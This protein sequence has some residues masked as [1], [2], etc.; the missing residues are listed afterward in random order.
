M[1]LNLTAETV[2]ASLRRLAANCLL[3]IHAT[4]EGDGFNPGQG[5]DVRNFFEGNPPAEIVWTERNKLAASWSIMIA[6]QASNLL[7]KAVIHPGNG[8]TTSDSPARQ[9]AI[10]VL[11]QRN[12]K[13]VAALE[14][15]YALRLK[16]PEEKL[17][18]RPI[19]DWD[20]TPYYWEFGGTPE[21]M[22]RLLDELGGQYRCLIDFSHAI[23]TV[24]QAQI[25]AERVPALQCC[26]SLERVVHGFMDLPHCEVCHFSGWPM[27]RLAGSHG[28]RLTPIPP[29]VLEALKTH[30]VICLERR[31]NP[32]EP[33]AT[34]SDL[35]TFREALI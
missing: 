1:V 25:W 5:I 24:H 19:P 15:M 23:V 6:A 20:S 17:I 4:G 2:V 26:Q 35:A 8:Q 7:T 34:K 11:Q 18:N 31:W 28:E 33:E 12:K 30:K 10:S 21:D 3:F 9:R 13:K 29:I 16:R 32:D 27:G 14:N 22:R